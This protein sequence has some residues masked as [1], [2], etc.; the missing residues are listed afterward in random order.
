MQDAQGV[1]SRMKNRTQ[2][3]KTFFRKACNVVPSTLHWSKISCIC[4]FC[5]RDSSVVK[6]FPLLGLIMSFV[7]SGSCKQEV[8]KLNKPHSG[9]QSALAESLWWPDR[10][11][12]IQHDA[13]IWLLGNFPSSILQARCV[14]LWYVRA[15]DLKALLVH[16]NVTF[17]GGNFVMPVLFHWNFNGVCFC[18]AVFERSLL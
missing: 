10:T 7:I 1:N 9:N 18:T 8:P 17:A 11:R 6:W 4:G 2:T 3:H 14:S 15:G 13:V 16:R 5:L 12:H